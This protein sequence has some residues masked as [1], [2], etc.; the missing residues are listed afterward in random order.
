MKDC[1]F[2]KIVTGDIPCHKIYEDK[3]TFAFLDVHPV[4]KGHTLVI[5]KKHV[6]DIFEASPS[7]LKAL[8]VAN[9]KIARAL[10][11][12]A[13][14]VNVFMNNKEAAG[15]IVFHLHYHV[16]PRWKDDGINPKLPHQSYSDTEM[17]RIAEN[18]RKSLA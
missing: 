2:C 10:G 18:I 12:S 1:V 15:Q 4:N 5:P 14:G 17:K 6:K 8:S 13:D 9:Q 16:F 3:D 11:M 7:I